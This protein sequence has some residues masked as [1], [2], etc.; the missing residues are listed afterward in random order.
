MA[1]VEFQRPDLLGL[2]VIYG[3]L[4]IEEVL[5]TV[6]TNITQKQDVTGIGVILR[7]IG[8]DGD[9]AVADLDIV[10]RH[11]RPVFETGVSFRRDLDR[12]V[13]EAPELGVCDP[14]Q[15]EKQGK[16]QENPAHDCRTSS[17]G[18]PNS[19]SK[20]KIGSKSTP[21]RGLDPLLS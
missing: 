17:V 10:I 20:E 6:D 18:G 15:R 5:T 9:S 2:E 16:N 14:S 1:S 11:S 7:M 13:T 8:I 3:S 19:H 12:L 4:A 21:K